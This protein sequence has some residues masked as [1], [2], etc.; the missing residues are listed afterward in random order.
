MVIVLLTSCKRVQ[1]R[2]DI[3]E[4]IASFSLE[5]SVK[6][7]LEG[8]YTQTTITTT[9]EE[10]TK[11]IITFEFNVKEVEKPQYKKVVTT[12]K[13][14]EFQKEV[15]EEVIIYDDKYYIYDNSGMHESTLEECHSKVE[16]FFYEEVAF[17]GTYHSGGMFRG[18]YIKQGIEYFQPYAAINEEATLL[19]FDISQDSYDSNGLQTHINSVYSVNKL[20]ML[21]IQ[22]VV[23]TKEGLT[24]TLHLEVYKKQIFIQKYLTDVFYSNKLIVEYYCPYFQENR[25]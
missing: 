24:K 18:D 13:N 14:D 1:I 25:L 7:Y 9:S 2:S 21:T 3:A 23:G 4:F 10:V 22:D 11:E 5:N 15:K 19:T 16:K 8:G 6:E 17:E 20:G 12:F